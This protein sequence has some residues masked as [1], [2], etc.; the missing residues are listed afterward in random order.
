VLLTD[1]LV[2]LANHT[3]M[4]TIDEQGNPQPPIDLQEVRVGYMRIAPE[5]SRTI[6]GVLSALYGPTDLREPD[7]QSRD[8]ALL[9]V[10]GA[11]TSAARDDAYPQRPSPAAR[12]ESNM[13][14]TMVGYG[15]T[16]LGGL[17]RQRRTLTRGFD[18][19]I[20]LSFPTPLE[21]REDIAPYSGPGEGDS[22][23]PL[24]RLLDERD[25]LIREQVGVHT[26]GKTGPN[27]TPGY[28][29]WVRLDTQWARD[30]LEQAAGQ[31]A[32]ALMNDTP[33][34]GRWYG[35]TDYGGPCRSSFDGDCD[36]NVD[37]PVNCPMVFDE[38]T[39]TYNPPDMGNADTT[40]VA[41]YGTLYVEVND[42]AVVWNGRGGLGDIV[43]GPGR[44]G[45]H[46][47]IGVEARVADVYS[48]GPV[49]V[50]PRASI[51]GV[52]TGGGL[53]GNAPLIRGKPRVPPIALSTT[54]AP[55]GPDDDISLEPEQPPRDIDPGD[56][57]WVT[58]KRASQL[59]LST[60]V[61]HFRGL[62]LDS[63]GILG[64]DTSNGPIVLYVQERLTIRGD[65]NGNTRLFMLGY[66]G[67]STVP[68]E[69][70]LRATLVAP[71]AHVNLAPG[72]PHYG[73]VYA[74]SV[75]LHQDSWFTFMP[76]VC[77]M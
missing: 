76:F 53:S 58:V 70:T 10:S 54:F 27:G 36:R 18:D 9:I 34:P 25:K 39:K 12:A 8:I 2:L 40:S 71:R 69:D 35:E 57:R 1:R 13:P 48:V 16:D 74:E 75:T 37:D 24:F 29:I 22:G 20:V 61:Y 3:V 4:G 47:R 41:L 46:T 42:R 60:G 32:Y 11:I 15:Q 56:Y 49:E 52:L 26:R 44:W 14:A 64:L 59:R 7:H 23:G 51:D 21:M 31:E 28:S 5:H 19:P 50:A 66:M 17:P 6:Q 45:Q 30:W 72:M 73:A 63:Q 62:T 68:V 65:I 33:V 43:A 67:T 38:G 77:S 55:T